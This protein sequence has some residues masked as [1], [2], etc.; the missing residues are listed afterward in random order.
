MLYGRYN[1]NLAIVKNKGFYR[2]NIDGV[3]LG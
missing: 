3:L 1:Y 2:T